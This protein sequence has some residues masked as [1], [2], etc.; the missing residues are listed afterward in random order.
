[1]PL[2]AERLQLQS[3]ILLAAVVEFESVRHSVYGFQS[4]RLEHFTGIIVNSRSNLRQRFPCGELHKA[5]CH[6]LACAGDGTGDIELR[7]WTGQ[8]EA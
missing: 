5:A 4:R 1:M 2:R 8:V 7:F 6:V 3:C